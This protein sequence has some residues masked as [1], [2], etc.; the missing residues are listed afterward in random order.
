MSCYEWERATLTLPSAAVAP[1]KKALRDHANDFHAK[2]RAEAVRLHKS[3]GT[4]S[5]TKYRKALSEAERASWDKPEPVRSSFY[6]SPPPAPGTAVPDSMV[7]SVA[8]D[9]LRS[10]LWAVERDGATLRQPTVADVEKVA[11]RATNRTTCFSVHSRRGGHEA[12][13]SFDGRTV[14]W[15]VGENNHAVEH[16]K[17]APLAVLFFQELDKINWTRG[18][19]GAGVG[20]NEY[21]RDDEYAGGGANY[22]TFTY[23]PLGDEVKAREMGLSLAKYRKMKAESERQTYRRVW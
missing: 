10:I 16:A 9:V 18:T 3:F 1:L 21:N 14:T 19:G 8:F 22:T 7:Q 17:E 23:G 6:A 2:V 20:N 5:L 11:P 13:I 4:R 12:T 15:D